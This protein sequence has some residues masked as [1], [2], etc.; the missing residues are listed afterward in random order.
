MQGSTGCDVRVV[1]KQG[2]AVNGLGDYV[3][4]IFSSSSGV[5]PWW[6]VLCE[7]G[8]LRSATLFCVKFPIARYLVVAIS[9]YLK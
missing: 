7:T 2:S 3:E 8:V 1:S 5:A 4:E 9:V 6:L